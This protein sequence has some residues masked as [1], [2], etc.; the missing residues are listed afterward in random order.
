MTRGHFRGHF[1]FPELGI[2][3]V[4]IDDIH[5]VT[6]LLA[7][8]ESPCQEIAREFVEKYK[9]DHVEP[10]AAAALRTY[11]QTLWTRLVAHLRRESAFVGTRPELRLLGQFQDIKQGHSE[12]VGNFYHRLE[13]IRR[14]L[15]AQEPPYIADPLTVWPNTWKQ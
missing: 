14:Q 13:K 9:T 2:T 11:H 8:L 1:I 7:Y 10:V 5:K 15:G 4:N 6:H 12:T 3:C